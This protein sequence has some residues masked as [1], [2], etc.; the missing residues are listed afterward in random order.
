[1]ARQC[2]RGAQRSQAPSCAR[3]LFSMLLRPGADWRLRD[4]LESE[5]GNTGP[6]GR[7]CSQSATRIFRQPFEVNESSWGSAR[8]PRPSSPKKPA[9]AQSAARSLLIAPVASAAIKPSPEPFQLTSFRTSA[10]S[11]VFFAGDIMPPA[12]GARLQR[13][14]PRLLYAPVRRLPRR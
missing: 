11:R 2:G 10:T 9:V 8:G 14:P 12:A 1:M 3:H 7:N 4:F 6:A 5:V 13:S